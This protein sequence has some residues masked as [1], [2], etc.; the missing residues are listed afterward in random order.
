MHELSADAAA[1]IDDGVPAGI[2]EPTE[3]TGPGK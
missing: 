3:V 2:V 1:L